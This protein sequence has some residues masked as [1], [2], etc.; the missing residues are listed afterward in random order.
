[1]EAPAVDFAGRADRLWDEFQPLLVYSGWQ[2]TG[3]GIGS[4]S[5]NG[6]ITILIGAGGG[7]PFIC[8]TQLAEQLQSQTRIQVSVRKDQ[9]TPKLDQCNDQCVEIQIGDA[10]MR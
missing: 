7:D 5:Y 1:M 8:G 3:G 4:S 9:V 6:G 2:I 10:V